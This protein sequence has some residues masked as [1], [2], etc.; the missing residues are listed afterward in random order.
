MV[1]DATTLQPIPA[2]IM[3]ALLPTALLMGDAG[4]GRLR[5][6]QTTALIVSV[7]LF[8][9]FVV[10]AISLMKAVRQEGVSRRDSSPIPHQ[11]PTSTPSRARGWFRSSL[12]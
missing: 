8:A 6:L 12:R 7:P 9:I 5:S 11:I 4:D 2:A 3:L 1:R 10:M